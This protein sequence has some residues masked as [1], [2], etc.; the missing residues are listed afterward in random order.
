MREPAVWD[1]RP[2]RSRLAAYAVSVPTASAGRR[3]SG[4]R[5]LNCRGGFSM[6]QNRLCIVS[7][8]SQGCVGNW[9]FGG[10]RN[11]A[12]KRPNRGFGCAGTE[13]IVELPIMPHIVPVSDCGFGLAM[14]SDLG[15][16]AQ[17]R[18]W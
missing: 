6:Q 15:R 2:L 12:A 7:R 3:R 18:W 8:K 10:D 4:A 16:R 9:L 11:L 1:A 13:T 5:I 17:D 14:P